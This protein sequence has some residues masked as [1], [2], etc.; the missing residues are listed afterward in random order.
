MTEKN[1]PTLFTAPPPR[2][3]TTPARGGGTDELPASG[4]TEAA[5]DVTPKRQLSPAV[6]LER[7]RD[8]QALTGQTARERQRRWGPAPTSEGPPVPLNTRPTQRSGQQRQIL[9][10]HA[11]YAP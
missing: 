8:R 9:T 2:H 7:L 1:K 10:I 11:K 4:F 3:H 5:E 6:S